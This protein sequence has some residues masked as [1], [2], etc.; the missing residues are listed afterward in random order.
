MALPPHHLRSIREFVAEELTHRQE[1]LDSFAAAPLPLYER[2]HKTGLANWWLAEDLGGLGLGLAD[3]VDIVSELAYGDAGAAFTLFVSILG[4]SI[5]ELYGSAEL[6]TTYLEPMA[7]NGTFCATVG[8]E[9]EAGSELSRITT[10]ATRHRDEVVLTGEKYFSTNAGFADFYIVI[11]RAAEATD[12]YLAVLVPRDTPGLRVVRR[13]ETIGLRSSGTYQLSLGDCRVPA[14]NVLAGHG[15]RL[16]EFGLNASR[17]L[18]AATAV[19]IA[20]RI[21]DLS[22]EY[23]KRKHLRGEPLTANAVFAAKLGQMETSIEV[24]RNQCLAAAGEYDTLMAAPDAAAEFRRQGSLRSALTTKLFCGQTGWSIAG[25]GSEMFG[26]LG[27][28][29]GSIIGKL[30]RD[31]RY[32]AIVE[33]G[34]DV[35]RDIVYSRYVVPPAKRI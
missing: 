25:T 24:M 6:R 27:Y 22:M 17:I 14:A 18:I 16:L 1:H 11:A 3:S 9:D 28:T 7:R 29:T 26:G 20:R 19:G 23:G 5:V 32:I 21:R 12:G 13:W 15:L 35:L 34:E 4:T 30:V 31:M 2:F 33:G 10:T 8:S